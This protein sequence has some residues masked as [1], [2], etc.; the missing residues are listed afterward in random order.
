MEPGWLAAARTGVLAVSA[1]LL[2]AVW[3]ARGLPELRWLAY[4]VLA[5]GAGKVLVQDVPQGRAASLV[6]ALAL[7]GIALIVAPRWL[8]AR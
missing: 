1:I 8:K 6:A 2:A 3:R 5:V 7:Y 4:T